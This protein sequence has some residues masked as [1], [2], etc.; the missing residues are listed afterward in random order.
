MNEILYKAHK[1]ICFVEMEFVLLVYKRFQR[2]LPAIAV[3]VSA[4]DVICED[5]TLLIVK[6]LRCL[7]NN[8]SEKYINWRNQKKKKAEKGRLAF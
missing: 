8:K 2:F 4:F 6:R 7:V 1:R 5:M 3:L